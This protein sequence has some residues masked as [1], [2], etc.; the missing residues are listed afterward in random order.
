MAT[1]IIRYPRAP[2]DQLR[3]LLKPGEFLAPVMALN[4]AKFKGTELDVHFRDQ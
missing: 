4:R 1:P 2:S 3:G